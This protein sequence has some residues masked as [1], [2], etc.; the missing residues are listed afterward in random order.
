MIEIGSNLAWALEVAL[1][2]A[3][4]IAYRWISRK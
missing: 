2:C 4:I 1:V 3:T